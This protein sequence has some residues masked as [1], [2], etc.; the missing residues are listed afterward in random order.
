M[1][2]DLWDDLRATKATF[3]AYINHVMTCNKCVG[4]T[5]CY[6]T[7]GKPLREAHL[8]DWGA[9]DSGRPDRSTPVAQG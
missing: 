7:E 2:K 4:A 8:R 3:T 1:A 6:C 9:T 5:G